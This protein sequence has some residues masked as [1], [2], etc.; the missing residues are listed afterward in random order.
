MNTIIAVLLALALAGHAGTVWAE[1]E[2]TPQPK[3]ATQIALEAGS[4]VGTMVYT[5]LKGALC[6]IGLGT[7]P[8]LYV[9][10]GPKA[11]R[12]VANATCNGTWV[13]TPE[14]LRGE[15]PL[16]VVKETPCCG[17]PAP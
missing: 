4:I 6:L 3:S 13:I 14:V 12:T 8:L 11:A 2:A 5:P 15:T 7:T 1:G 9:S 16:T 17:Y 10:S